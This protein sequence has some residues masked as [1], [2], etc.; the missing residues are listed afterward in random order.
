MKLEIVEVEVPADV[1]IILGQAHFIK[2]IE[3]LYETLV[4]SSP[5]L[6]FG[7]AFCEA[8]GKRLVRSDGNDSSLIELAEKE[9]LKLGCGHSF[10]VYI[11]EGYPINV[12]KRIKNVSEVVNI[13]AATANDLQVVIAE[14]N[15]GRGIMGVIDGATPL[16][17]EKEEDRKWRYELLRKLGYK[18]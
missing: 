12:L 2:T 18:K 5:S 9:A 13:F 3:D 4:E 10:I 8:S 15:G 17:V 16:G 6:K 11:K 1:N 14:N 7:L